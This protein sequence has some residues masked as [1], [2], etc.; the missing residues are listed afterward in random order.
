MKVRHVAAAV[1]LG[2]ALS[3]TPVMG[4]VAP[5]FAEEAQSGLVPEGTQVTYTVYDIETLKPLEGSQTI[6]LTGG[7]TIGS[8]VGETPSKDGYEFA[9][10][11]YSEED[12]APLDM[13]YPVLYNDLYGTGDNVIY[14]WFEKDSGSDEPAATKQIDLTFVTKDGLSS[15]ALVVPADPGYGYLEDAELPDFISDYLVD[16]D[17]ESWTFTVDGVDTTIQ[18]GDL[19]VF[20]FASGGTLTANYAEEEA[21]STIDVTLCYAGESGEAVNHA[22]TVS[23]NE[24]G[25]GYLPDLDVLHDDDID[26]WYYF[27]DD[28]KEYHI[29]QSDLASTG[30]ATDG[31]VLTAHYKDASASEGET[32]RYITV[33][34]Y[35]DQ[36]NFLGDGAVLNGTSDWSYVEAP[37]REGYTF[38]GWGPEG[39]TEGFTEELLGNVV[40]A[41]DDT[42]NEVTYIAHYRQNST[43]YTVNFFDKDGNGLCTTANAGD[44]RFGKYLRQFAQSGARIPY[45]RGYV[46]DGWVTRSGDRILPGDIISTDLDVY[47]HY[48][49]VRVPDNPGTDTPVTPSHDCPSKNFVDIDQNAWYHEVVDWA[50]ENGVMHGYDGGVYFGPE[51]VLT[52]AQVAG[53]LYN[54]AGSPEVDGSKVAELFPDCDPNEWYAEAVVWAQES[55][56]FM[57][58]GD[59]SFAPND[60][61]TR[62][63]MFVVLWRVQGCPEADQDLSAFPDGD[64]TSSWAIEGVNWAVDEGLLRGYTATG[65]LKP[66]GGLSRAECAAV[67]QRYVEAFGTDEL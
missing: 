66:T 20:P 67:A 64:T 13:S 1:G 9:G 32:G 6:R 3:L 52:R 7:A 10:F 49:K 37:Y 16:E 21:P 27:G 56:V 35:D 55:G 18:Q 2:L 31:L 36:G 54:M 23:L 34:F 65:E 26:Y 45:V 5:A 61:I 25:W 63:Q 50:I 51:D 46:F 14:A 40:V 38:I 57:G 44:V 12:S 41:F 60:A 42:V 29:T 43:V 11:S 19:G 28:G 53:V 17:I 15:Y 30:L 8:Y 33:H 62:E 22:L 24:S 4:A 59:G 58:F 48:T 39:A 47:A